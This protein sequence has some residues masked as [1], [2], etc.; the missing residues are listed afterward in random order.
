[1][2]GTNAGTVYM[3]IH[4]DGTKVFLKEVQAIGEQ[5]Q[6]TLSKATSNITK[7]VKNAGTQAQSSMSKAFG[8]IAKMA[9]AAFSVAAVASFGKACVRAASDAQ[10]A[11]TGLSSILNAQGKDFAAANQYIKD[12]I[13]DGLVPAADAV[14]AY[15]NLAARGYDDS[16]IQS[17]LDRLKE[18][19]AFG[20]QASYSYGE[21]IRSA[22]EGLKNENSMLVDNAGVTK[23]VAKMWDEYARSIGTTSKNLTQAQ[24]IQAEV[25]GIQ[26]ETAF[27]VGDSAKYTRTYAGRVAGLSASFTQLKTSIGNLVIPIITQVLP[28]IQLA[29]DKVTLLAE[30][31]AKNFGG[32][33]NAAAT[34]AASS[35]SSIGDSAEEAGKQAKKAAKSLLAFDEINSLQKDDS[36]EAGSTAPS[37]GGAAMS[38][39][40]SVDDGGSISALQGK[41]DGLF[42]WLKKTFGGVW[43]DIKRGL[44]LVDFGAIK[45]NAIIAFDSLKLIA[46]AA[47]DGVQQVI[48]ARAAF[49]GELLAQGLSI[50]GKSVEIYTGAV[51]KFLNDNKTEI[52][53]WIA[54]IAE[55]ISLVFDNL[56][57]IVK[58]VGD[59]LFSSLDENKEKIM[60]AIAE[61]QVG[62]A[63]FGMSIVSSITENMSIITG[64]WSAW[65]TDNEDT[66]KTFFDNAIDVF[67]KNKKLLGKIAGETGE[68]I[69]KNYNEHFKGVVDGSSKMATDVAGWFLSLYN[70]NL[71]P[72][73]DEMFEWFNK[74]WDENLKDV[75][76][77]VMGFVGRI[78]ELIMLLYEHHIKP[79]IEWLM[80]YVVPIIK[81]VVNNIINNVMNVVNI[82]IGV[83]KSILKVIN[84][85]IDFL[86][87]VFTGDWDR[88]WSGICKIFEGIGD[89][90]STIINGIKNFF[91]IGFTFIKEYVT[92]IFD[93]VW[94]TIK[95]VFDRVKL[96]ISGSID[97]IKDL[98]SRGFNAVYDAV[99][100]IFNSVKKFFT[101]TMDN[102]TGIFSSAV[103]TIKNIFDK[104]KEYV[105]AP[106]NY[107][108]KGINQ[109]IDGAN[110]VKFDVPD[111]VPVI[112]GK[113]F[114]FNIPNIPELATG[115]I[116]TQPTLAMMGEGGK[117]EAVL[118]LEQNTGWMDDLA[119]R[120][121]SSVAAVIGANSGQ[122]T[123]QPEVNVYLDGTQVSRTIMSSFNREQQRRTTNLQGLVVT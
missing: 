39:P 8:S 54:E 45:N 62:F 121:A 113:I 111:W 56:R 31:I 75:V 63:N 55:K 43:D 110:K 107:V 69:T 42:G 5:A 7:D 97:N 106:I 40:L 32:N 116:I 120:V 96:F 25:L 36:G 21:A 2:P 102:L 70:D 18:S 52:S 20:R 48:Q 84:G 83:V 64:N 82:I 66:I 53:N 76:D 4:T 58:T 114:G 100:G 98:F 122:S 14:T 117:R 19:A 71:K 33:L 59:S 16:Q 67:A 57:K 13:K 60:D 37:I 50:V 49:F 79:I 11:F 78:G 103:D 30:T 101:D 22:T 46:S 3:A 92:E 93:A 10:S 6:K 1:M 27:Q 61:M 47:L 99:K 38:M 123:G 24:K 41:F 118:P 81:T 51:A 74:I 80:K 23:N 26:K 90:I 108:I 68:L 77:E 73:V 95:D 85:I 44:S 115:G 89:Y 9:A 15:K 88:A 112:G 105:K 35:I 94:G 17:T 87:G 29:I 119:M 72:I 28:Y 86:I 104:V 65:A 91:I 12:Y 34:G 109:L